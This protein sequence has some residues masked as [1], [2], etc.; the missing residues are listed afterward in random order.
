[1]ICG[2]SSR[3]SGNVAIPPGKQGIVAFFF[4]YP[5]WEVVLES[6]RPNCTSGQGRHIC[7]TRSGKA[8]ISTGRKDHRQTNHLCSQRKRL[9]SFQNPERSLS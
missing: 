8:G 3:S 7:L 6:A 5:G 9:F 4:V 1:M 2:T